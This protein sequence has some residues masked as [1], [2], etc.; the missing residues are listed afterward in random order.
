[1]YLNQ[2]S[3]FP[4]GSVVKNL[5]ANGGRCERLGFIPWVRKIPLS[6]KW[7]PTPGYLPGES[8]RGTELA[9]SSPRGLK[10]VRQLSTQHARTVG[11]KDSLGAYSGRG[12]DQD[13]PQGW[14]RR[15][16]CPAVWVTHRLS[17]CVGRGLAGGAAPMGSQCSGRLSWSR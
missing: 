5:P 12:S 3:G 4:G 10:R 17:H 13:L 8:H 1:M 6:R 14:V 16:L 7:Q 9:G 2:S 15:C 11:F